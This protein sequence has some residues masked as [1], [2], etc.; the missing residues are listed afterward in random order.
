MCHSIKNT[1]CHPIVLFGP[2]LTALPVSCLSPMLSGM[3]SLLKRVEK[4]ARK[5]TPPRVAI[6]VV[7]TVTGLLPNGPVGTICYAIFALHSYT[8]N[9]YV[10]Y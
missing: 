5:G 9:Q 6:V 10:C 3:V 4:E 1:N 8:A 2:R 7:A